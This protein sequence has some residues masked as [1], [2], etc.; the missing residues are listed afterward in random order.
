[1]RPLLEDSGPVPLRGCRADLKGWTCR[2]WAVFGVLVQWLRQTPVGGTGGGRGTPIL[3]RRVW[4]APLTG[5][6]I[7]KVLSESNARPRLK[8]S[9]LFQACRAGVLRGSRRARGNPGIGLFWE[10]RQFCKSRFWRSGVTCQELSKSGHSS[11]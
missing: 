6:K 8:P 4:V 11:P 9:A 5:F 3:N 1:M 2:V 10:G 7:S